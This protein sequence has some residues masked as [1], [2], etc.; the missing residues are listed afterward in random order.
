[1]RIKEVKVLLI[2]G[3]LAK[4]IVKSYVKE[5]SVETQTLALKIAV[6]AFLTSQTIVEQIKSNKLTDFN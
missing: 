2:T 6:A 3:Q 5:S 4:D 1:M